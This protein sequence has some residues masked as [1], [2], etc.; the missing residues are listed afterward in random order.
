MEGHSLQGLDLPPPFLLAVN[1]DVM[2]VAH[3]HPAPRGD[4]E[5]GRHELEWWG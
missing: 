4:L 2:A 5:D 1:E 3:T